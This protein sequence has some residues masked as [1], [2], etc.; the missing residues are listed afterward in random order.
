LW[1]SDT[2]TRTLLDP[3]P[4]LTK[5]QTNELEFGRVWVR[6]ENTAAGRG[7]VSVLGSY[8]RDAS[9]LVSRF[10]GTPTELGSDADVFGA[11]LA[12]K[13]S[14]NAWLSAH[15][16]LD[17]EA[18]ASS[19]H[20]AGSIGA[21]PREGDARVFGQPPPDQVNSDAWKTVVASL[22]P[23]AELDMSFLGG[24][25][26]VVPGA[27]LEPYL[28]TASRLVPR[29][30]DAP[31]VGSSRE[32]TVLEPRIRARYAIGTRLALKGAFGVYHQPPAAEDLSAVFGAPR[33]GTAVAKHYVGGATV[34]LS[35]AID[36]DLT[37]FASQSEDLAARSTA[38][39]P[40][41][42]QALLMQ[43][44]G[45]AYGAQL[46]LRHQK[47]GRFFGWISYSV[48]RSERRDAP[49]VDWRLFDYDQT[50]V[51]TA[52]GSYDLGLGFEVGARLRV[53]TG[54]PRTPVSGAYYDTRSDLYQP[55]FGP[56]N[57]E[58]IPPFY[59]VDVR[60]AKRFKL[61]ATSEAELFVD[62]QNATNHKNP[63]EIV[64]T[65]SYT[66][67]DYIT[68]LPLLPVVGAKWTF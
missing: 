59:A 8:G 54:F 61:S 30:G 40:L 19:V 11:R 60:V 37:G 6:Y 20:R 48:L 34:G 46:L 39:T 3:D 1:S 29:V 67:K 42:A 21:P 24:A 28:T 26:H 58:R 50:H 10:G 35:E 23:H 4:A 7:S 47:T 56:R 31:V 52:L 5:R 15:V 66:R 64:Y 45:R 22:A 65:R 55:V 9:S 57:I 32:E 63:E 43:A 41:L 38:S 62:L 36:L 16:G 17:V 49:G 25:L 13:G 33:L 68:G 44:E 14:L 53:A 27:R 12:W 2:T 51:L 18:I